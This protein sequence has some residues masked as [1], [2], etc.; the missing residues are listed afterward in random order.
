MYYE[1]SADTRKAGV[2]RRIEAALEPE[3]VLK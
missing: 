2:V 1:A 3:N